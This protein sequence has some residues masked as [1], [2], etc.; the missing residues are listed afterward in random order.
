MGFEPSYG[1]AA[2]AATAA[3]DETTARW[4]A[5][6]ARVQTLAGDRK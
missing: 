3:N 6:L 4:L 5:R 2:L 1:G